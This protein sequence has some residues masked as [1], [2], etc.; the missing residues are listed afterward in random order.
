[1]V[2]LHLLPEVAVSRPEVCV[3]G[4]GPPS[5]CSQCLGA[6]VRRVE[7]DYERGLVLIDGAVVRRLASTLSHA[8]AHW[9]TQSHA[10]LE[11]RKKLG[12]KALGKKPL[13]KKVRR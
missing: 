12:R 11:A 3:H 10:V 5:T 1:V 2:L 6:S 7:L 9:Q 8:D 13:P 4:S